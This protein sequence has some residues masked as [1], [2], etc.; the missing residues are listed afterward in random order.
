MQTYNTT[1]HGVFTNNIA[2]KRLKYMDMR[3]HWLRCL[4][5]QGQLIHF[6][7]PGAINLGDFVTKH[8]AAIHH[9]TICPTFLNPKTH[10][11]IL[12]KCAY[13]LASVAA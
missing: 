5:T 13:S 9:H 11:Y 6:G 7:K 8:H 1:A 12:C 10:L 3:F 2:S 4:T